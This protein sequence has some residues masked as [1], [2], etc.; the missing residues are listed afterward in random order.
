MTMRKN[1]LLS[2][3]SLKPRGAALWKIRSEN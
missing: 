2:L 1:S 3:T